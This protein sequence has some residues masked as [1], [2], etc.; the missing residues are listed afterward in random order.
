MF[1]Y[2][3]R[4]HQLQLIALCDRFILNDWQTA[5]LAFFEIP[6]CV[7]RHIGGNFRNYASKKSY[8]QTS[9]PTKQRILKQRQIS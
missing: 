1:F 9:W 4:E 7:K 5:F 6:E 2:F 3:R 8:D